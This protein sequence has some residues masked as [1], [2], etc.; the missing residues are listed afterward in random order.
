MERDRSRPGATDGS[1]VCVSPPD[2]RRR[3]RRAARSLPAR[4]RSSLENTGSW[5]RATGSNTNG[6][7]GSLQSGS[8]ACVRYV[9]PVS[10][11]AVQDRMIGSGAHRVARI[12]HDVD[13]GQFVL[14]AAKGIAHQPLDPITLYGITDCTDG[15]GQAQS[16]AGS[17]VLPRKHSEEGITGPAGPGIDAVELA[18]L[19]QPLCRS[20]PE[21]ALVGRRSRGETNACAGRTPHVIRPDACGLLRADAK[22]PV[23]R[24]SLPSGH[25]SHEC[26]CDADCWVD[27]CASWNASG[28]IRHVKVPENKVLVAVEKGGKGTHGGGGCQGNRRLR[29]AAAAFDRR[30]FFA[31]G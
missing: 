3:E 8:G 25:G 30:T 22:A 24:P 12:H 4:S 23:G 29:R 26:A 15:D 6:T 10:G 16:R 31:C 11:E 20:Q 21:S 2:T 19:P 5:R 1:A 18:L 28:S 17:A 9:L 27:R 13:G 7:S 14:T